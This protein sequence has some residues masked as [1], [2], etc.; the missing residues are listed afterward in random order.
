MAKKSRIFNIMQ[1]E[2]HPDT[3]ETIT[4]KDADGNIICDADGQPINY[5][6]TLE[7]IEAVVL[8]YKS[9]TRWAFVRHDRDVYS[10]KDEEDDPDRK[11]GKTKPPHW[12]VV[13]EGKNAI[14]LET[15]AKWFCIPSQFID[16]PKGGRRS[17]LD[18]VEY[19]TH[20]SPKEQQQGKTLYN[21]D[22]VVAN[23]N[24]REALDARKDTGED[25]T[26]R[27]MLRLKVLRGEMTLRDIKEQFPLDFLADEAKLKSAREAYVN[28]FA[29]TPM[30]RVNYYITGKGGDGKGLAA[31]A[32]ARSLFPNYDR[33]EDIFF[34]VGR[35]NITFDG[36]DGQPVIIWDDFRAFELLQ[37]CGG[38]GNFFDIFDTHPTTGAGNRKSVKFGSTRLLNCV[39]IVNSV[40]D[41]K[42]FLDALV[43]EYEDAK[44]KKHQSE[45][46][47][48]A[49]SYRRFPIIMPLNAD[50][51]EILINK[52]V[53]E[54]TREFEDYFHFRGIRG[55]FYK[56]AAR[57]LTN[58]AL[59][60]A[61]EAKMLLAVPEAHQ[62]ALGSGIEQHTEEEI[63]AEFADVGKPLEVIEFENKLRTL[64]QQFAE[65]SKNDPAGFVQSMGIMN[66]EDPALRSV[67]LSLLYGKNMK[68]D[69]TEYT[70]ED[71]AEARVQL[72]DFAK[73][74]NDVP[75]K[76]RPDA[77]K[78]AKGELDKTLQAAQR[79]VVGGVVCP[80]SCD[81]DKARVEY[82]LQMLRA[83]GGD[84]A[85]IDKLQKMRFDSSGSAIPEAY[86]RAMET[87]EK[88]EARAGAGAAADTGT[89]TD[90]VVPVP[91]V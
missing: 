33:D 59:Q 71:I 43:G 52:G 44:G 60:R 48:K 3:L 9:I 6:L 87:R 7:K 20:E 83:N 69:G 39:N 73:Q 81:T 85:V 32:V 53:M 64:Q 41:W 61:I 63:L 13:I 19:L 55:N 56:V 38:R 86:V 74:W 51:F 84:A 79:Q 5:G 75:A 50:D 54:G 57:C 72:S 16:V 30:S 88:Y 36:Y 49:Q 58:T 14:D 24:W 8:R 12:H 31:R 70:D 27:E 76:K 46:A 68:A 26:R 10:V 62:L 18:C 37:A 11:Q 22:E 29:P 89:D 35:G 21:D 2:K 80:V 15:V 40:Q 34:A 17:F 42:E 65:L 23:F 28:D 45:F 91:G 47:E 67:V 78:A 4:M 77:I 25:Y 1:Y 90:D 82:A 66:I